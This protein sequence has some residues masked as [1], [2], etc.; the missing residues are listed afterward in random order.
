MQNKSV[1]F[2][3]VTKPVHDTLAEE[4]TARRTQPKSAN[5]SLTLPIDFPAGAPSDPSFHPV[6]PF[7]RLQGNLSF[8][9]RAQSPASSSASALC[10]SLFLSLRSS[11]RDPA[12]AACVSF[13][14]LLCRC[15][16]EGARG[17]RRRRRTSREPEPSVLRISQSPLRVCAGTSAW[18]IVT[19][20][21]Q[22]ARRKQDR[23]I[24]RSVYL[25]DVVAV[26]CVSFTHETQ[27]PIDGDDDA[28]GAE[29]R[30]WRGLTGWWI[31]FVFAYT[32]GREKGPFVGTIYLG[33][34]RGREE[35]G[36]MPLWEPSRP[37]E[38][39]MDAV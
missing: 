26:V 21:A 17:R 16:M 38:R 36:K 14:A 4:K 23:S 22:P 10:L 20:I 18:K 7:P 37:R 25:R 2:F 33:G 5:P 9:R 24:D 15:T 32:T 6:V 11:R 34:R 29:E 30:G 39:E 12:A 13:S 27:S 28:A 19:V 1:S 31:T 8:S 35:R 3:C